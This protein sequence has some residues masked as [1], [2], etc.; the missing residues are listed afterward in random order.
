MT[1]QA[2]YNLDDKQFTCD[3]CGGRFAFAPDKGCLVCSACGRQRAI[4]AREQEFVPFSYEQ[5]KGARD[6]TWKRVTA[7]LP[8]RLIHEQ[9]LDAARKWLKDE[10]AL[11]GSSQLRVEAVYLPYCVFKMKA[12]AD[13]QGSRGETHTETLSRSRDARGGYRQEVTK[14]QWSP[15]SGTIS[16]REEIAIE[17]VET[18]PNDSVG[19]LEWNFA[20]SRPFDESYLAGWQAQAVQLDLNKAYRE[21]VGVARS[22]LEDAALKQIGGDDQKITRLAP[23]FSEA[24]F[25]LV[26]LPVFSGSFL[27][28]GQMHPFAINGYTGEV[29]GDAPD[30]LKKKTVRWLTYGAL[31]VG[32]TIVY[33]GWM[34]LNNYDF[35]EII[36]L[37]LMLGSVVGVFLMFMWLSENLNIVLL[38]LLYALTLTIIGYT[39]WF[40]TESSGIVTATEVLLIVLGLFLLLASYFGKRDAAKAATRASHTRKSRLP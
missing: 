20:E 26:L 9:A 23:E 5:H 31:A 29:T 7:L 24:T 27:F 12:T 14:T 25:R 17:A 8:F 34:L 38:T 3:A 18:L 16:R 33:V 4:E 22:I 30:T 28:R 35:A 6:E 40:I 13:Y 21:A 37:P 1:E 15:A 36:G 39:L 32:L 11:G 10:G 2:Q 19:R